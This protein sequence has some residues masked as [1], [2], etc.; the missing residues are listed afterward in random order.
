MLEEGRNRRGK[1]GKTFP[2]QVQQSTAKQTTTIISEREGDVSAAVAFKNSLLIS[3][4]F[5][6]RKENQIK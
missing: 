6:V 5:L 2:W 1:L 3:F 4:V